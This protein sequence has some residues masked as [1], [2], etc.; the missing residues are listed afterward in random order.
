MSDARFSCWATLPGGAM[1][2]V[3]VTASCDADARQLAFE[4]CPRAVS[5]SCRAAAATP[6]EERR[7]G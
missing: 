3:E 2:L 6:R 7:H 4:T 5:V 1:R